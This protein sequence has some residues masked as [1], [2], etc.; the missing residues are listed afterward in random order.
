[1][2]DLSALDFS[3]LFTLNGFIALL[4]LTALEIVLGIDNIIF[5]SIISNA[6]EVPAEQRKA[7]QM[8]LALAMITRILLLLSLS[9]VMS[10]D[11][12]FVTV[13]DHPFSGRDMVLFDR[14][15]VPAVQGH[16]GD[17]GQGAGPR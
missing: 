1:M 2:L 14:R 11:R 17:P 3:V 13:F 10:L 16:R 5:I 4:T 15:S 6:L 12:P 7:G 8:G 9:W